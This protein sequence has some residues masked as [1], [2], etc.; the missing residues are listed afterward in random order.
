MATGYGAYIALPLI[1][2]ELDAATAR[3]TQLTEQQAK[4]L[5]QKCLTVLYYRDARSLNKYELAVVTSSGATIEGPLTTP[6]NWDVAEY[7]SGYE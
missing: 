3:G 6:A 5:L 4:Q 2:D 7:V 1:R